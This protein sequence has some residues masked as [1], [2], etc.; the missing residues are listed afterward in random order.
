MSYRS[1]AGR[2]V[3]VGRTTGTQR[4]RDYPSWPVH[5]DLDASKRWRQPTVWPPG[6][7]PAGVPE[8]RPDRRA[9][10][11]G[12]R[13]IPAGRSPG[14]HLPAGGVHHGGVACPRSDRTVHRMQTW[15]CRS[16]TPLHPG[17]IERVSSRRGVTAWG[18]GPIGVCVYGISPFAP[19]L[20]HI[21]HDEWPP[22]S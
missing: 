22:K 8:R 12:P 7:Q 20:P 5:V 15:L 10:Q 17:L 21:P 11:R 1:Q 4:W 3:V 6:G 13:G 16:P 18:R 9:V 14:C 19:T 2:S